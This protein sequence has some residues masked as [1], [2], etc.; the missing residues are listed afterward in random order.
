MTSM[1]PINYVKLYCRIEYRMCQ[2]SLK[3]T[4][5]HLLR[6]QQEGKLGHECCTKICII[7][8]PAGGLLLPGSAYVH[9]LHTDAI[10]KSRSNSRSA[11]E[12]IFILSTS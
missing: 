9:V 3:S 10:P 2:R 8:R 5:T 7:V 4:Q 12:T 6:S 11:R 1:T